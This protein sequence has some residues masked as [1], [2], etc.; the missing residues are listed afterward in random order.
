[1]HTVVPPL[2]DSVAVDSKLYPRIKTKL[3]GALFNLNLI[4]LTPK[5]SNETKY[6]RMDQVKFVKDSL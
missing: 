6:S 5:I 3:R 2:L 1:M 4:S